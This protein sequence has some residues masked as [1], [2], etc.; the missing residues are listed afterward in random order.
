M[1]VQTKITLL[2]V[3]VVAIFLAG[4]ASIRFYEKFNFR[5]IAESRFAERNRSFDNFL[6]SYGLPLKTLTEDSTCLDQL[7]QAAAQNDRAWF[8]QYF[9]DSM[10]A[11]FR[12]NAVWVFAQDGRL[13]FQHDNLRAQPPLV[14]PV[15]AAAFREI[16]AHEPLRHF[17]VK[18]PLGL[19]EIP[20][21][22]GA[23]LTGFPAG[24]ARVRL[25][26]RRPA[27]EPARTRQHDARF[28]YRGDVAL[29]E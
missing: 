26:L 13:V 20:R 17:F 2:L 29:H 12:A 16:F 25:L 22:H 27:L 5:R 15:P 23:S 28:R 4:L 3:C 7:V 18:V 8:A 21:R 9:S 11:G 10:L 24:I 1:K 19:M 6:E 14:L